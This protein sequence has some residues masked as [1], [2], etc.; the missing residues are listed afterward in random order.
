MGPLAY[1]NNSSLERR[2]RTWTYITE[3]ELDHT[4][5]EKDTY[6]LVLEGVKMGASIAVN[7]VELGNVTDQFL[8]FKFV[9]NDSVLGRSSRESPALRR[10]L[11]S[12]PTTAHQLSITF[13]SDIRTDGRFMACSSSWD[14]APYSRTGDERGSPV[15]TFGIFKP[16]YIVKEHFASITHVVPKIYYLGPY[17]RYVDA[18]DA[19]GCGFLHTY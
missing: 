13:D 6:V 7:G 1:Y 5:N 2:T 19:I 17:A 15:F 16:I 8:R 18:T 11:I 9:L 10:E 12:S 4:L 14:W 3:F